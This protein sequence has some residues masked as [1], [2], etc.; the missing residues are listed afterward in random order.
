MLLLFKLYIDNIDLIDTKYIKGSIIDNNTQLAI[1]NTLE[2]A[3]GFQFI[4]SKYVNDGI[5]NNN[6]FVATIISYIEFL[7]TIFCSDEV[8]LYN[9]FNDIDKEVKVIVVVIV[10][11]S[12][13]I[14]IVF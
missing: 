5:D 3:L 7:P 13:T 1:I 11:I 9:Y 6:N 4:R 14:I 12:I 10:A 8:T 2:N